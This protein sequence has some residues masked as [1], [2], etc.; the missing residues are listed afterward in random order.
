M[1]RLKS[2]VNNNIER[3][4]DACTSNVTLWSW[5]YFYSTANLCKCYIPRMLP[6]G[7]VECQ[8]IGNKLP[9]RECHVLRRVIGQQLWEPPQTRASNVP[10]PHVLL[11]LRYPPFTT[12]YIRFNDTI[13]LYTSCCICSMYLGGRLCTRWTRRYAC[14]P[15]MASIQTVFSTR[16]A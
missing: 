11:H 4:N 1:S 14:I 7:L 15:I 6:V 10:L 3:Y 8:R 13:Y 12:L 2:M 9:F 5:S 16:V